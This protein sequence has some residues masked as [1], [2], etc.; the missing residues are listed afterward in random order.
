MGRASKKARYDC[1]NN[2]PSYSRRGTRA[3][4]KIYVGRDKWDERKCCY[5]IHN[6]EPVK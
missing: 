1:K 5:S 6:L 4:G 3:A 2:D